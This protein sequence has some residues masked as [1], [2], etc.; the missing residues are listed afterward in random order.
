MLGKWSLGLCL[1]ALIAVASFIWVSSVGVK[2]SYEVSKNIRYGFLVE[3]STAEYIEEA[4]F[5]VFAPVKKNSYQQTV[6]ITASLPFDIEL[7]RFG[8]Q[9][10]VFK[11]SKLAPR[12]SQIVK[13]TV[14]LQLASEPQRVLL[15]AEAPYLVAEE[16]IEVDSPEIN[17]LAEKLSSQGVKIQN[18]ATW[19]NQNISDVGYVAEDRGAH[20]AITTK[21]GDCTEFSSAFVALARASSIPSRMIGGFI[22]EQSGRVQAENYHNWGEFRLDDA[23]HL[24]DPQNNKIDSGY[25]SY[26]AFYNFNKHSRMSNSHRFLSYDPRLS[27]QML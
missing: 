4:S 14:S 16:N 9:T 26:I 11:L 3:N 20:Y 7:D 25:G 23:W 22:L 15:D 21:Q 10:L 19:I 8:N 12:A 1:L 24:A 18:I 27:V 13:V 5:R 2:P 6:D 17:K